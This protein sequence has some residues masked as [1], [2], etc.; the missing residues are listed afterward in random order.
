[1]ASASITPPPVSTPGHRLVRR[2]RRPERAKG[3]RT[4]RLRKSRGRHA[5]N[6]I[7]PPLQKLGRGPYHCCGRKAGR[8]WL[9]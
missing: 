1:M 8:H 7:N 5:A 4:E 3:R 9:R 2:T 6:A